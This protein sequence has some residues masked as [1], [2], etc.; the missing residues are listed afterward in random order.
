MTEKTVRTRYA[1]S[2]TG[3]MH[4]GNLRTALYEYLVAKS[5]NGKFVLRIE[6]TDRERLVEGAVDV[7][8]DTMKLAGLKHDEGP[9]IGGDFGPYVQSE[10]KDMY[11]PYAE[12][13]IKEGKAYRCFCTKERLEKLQED[14]VGGGYDRHCRN[15]PQEEIDRLLAE[16]TPYVIRQKMPLEGTTTF[17]DEVYGDITVENSTLDDQI[18]IKTDGMPTYNFANVVDDHTMGITHVVRGN[19]YL[20]SAPKY[21]LLY[22]AFG[23][24]VP[25]YIHCSPVM[26]DQTTKLSKRNGDA[27]F[28][29]LLAKGYLKDAVV[30]F[31]ALLGWAP[32]G[33]QEIFS[34]DELVKE[35]DISGISKSPAIFDP[36]KLKAINA[37]YIRKMTPEE[38]LEYIT[39]YIRQ[40][41]K[42]EDIDL[43]LLA[44]VLQPRTELFTDIPEQV[45]FIDELPDYDTSMFCHKKMKTNE[46]TSLEALKAILPVLEGVDDWTVENIHT[47]LFDL[48][49]KLGVKNGWLLWPLRTA[50][51]GKQFTPGGGVE[52]CAI[53]GKE[54]SIAR[55]KKG[56]EK[57]S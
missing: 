56:I 45:D 21:N 12:Q 17:H 35:F 4:V 44:S 51:S 14:S 16:G 10:R 32:K 13:L 33:E 38:F 22:E 43:P 27:S 5:Q 53:L 18:L 15:L 42:R 9:D 26:K 36:I 29:D 1:P 24:E 30:N 11:L 23:W 55:I 49:A 8:Y 31:I 48:I 2:P 25:T 50:V 52:L 57:L 41:V 47:A 19:E 7:I 20:S 39:P 40:T 6:D 37:A 28:E 34:L 54:D 3:F 46:E